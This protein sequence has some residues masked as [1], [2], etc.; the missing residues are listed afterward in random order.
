MRY[1][2]EAFRTIDEGS[3]LFQC[4]WKVSKTVKE[5]LEENTLDPRRLLL[6]IDDFLNTTPPAEWRRRATDN[7]PLGDMPLRT[8]KTILQQIVSVKGEGV[9]D[10][11]ALVDTPENSFVYQ[12]L[13]RLLNNSKTLDGADD[14][15]SSRARSLSQPRIGGSPQSSRTNS[16]ITLGAGS[17][18]RSR[19][20][21]SGGS[22][23]SPGR[24]SMYA[25]SGG[26]LHEHEPQPQGGALSGEVEINQ[27]L[28]EIFDKIGRPQESKAVSFSW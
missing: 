19:P 17:L 22:L 10:E 15:G 5:S 7:V 28:K 23:T 24:S 18:H 20:S 8:V 1:L 11:L 3:S 26:D 13:F 21:E 16:T 14:A 6:D 27:R 12:Y 2:T 25:N 4:L 9:Y